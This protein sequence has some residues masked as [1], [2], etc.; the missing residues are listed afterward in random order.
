[1]HESHSVRN[2]TAL[3]SELLQRVERPCYEHLA[4]DAAA[5]KH[6]VQ[7]ETEG[8]SSKT[9]CGNWVSAGGSQPA[10]PLLPSSSL[11]CLV[12]IL[13]A[14]II[15]LKFRTSKEHVLNAKLS[16]HTC[17]RPAIGSQPV[18]LLPPM[19]RPD[20]HAAEPRYHRPGAS[21][22]TATSPTPRQNVKDR[23]ANTCIEPR[24]DS[25]SVPR[26]AARAA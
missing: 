23:Y 10:M 18:P 15:K 24:R 2:L 17:T 5:R 6:K 22:K 9:K 14:V 11:P 7:A 3:S 26:T 1:M 20:L 16:A 8:R 13:I 4:T 19:P 25:V 12:S 21:A